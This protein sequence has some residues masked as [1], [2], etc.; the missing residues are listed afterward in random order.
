MTADPQNLRRYKKL[1]H[2]SHI[3]KRPDTYIGSIFPL[4]TSTFIVSLDGEVSWSNLTYSPALLK[5]FDEVIQNCYDHSKRPE[6][7]HIN[8][9]DVTINQITGEITVTDNGGIPVAKHPD[10]G[11]YIPDMIFGELM[12][13]ENYNEDEG[14]EREGAGTN[15]LGSKL[16][17][18]YSTQFK[19]E[20]A[21]GKNRYEK[22]RKSVV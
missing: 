15:G 12:S 13:G 1:D 18:I 4:E 11:Q 8:K 16:T 10:L 17:N 3:L 14:Q 22:D 5:I 9:I 20:T 7:K 19:V 6:G 2:I 21:D